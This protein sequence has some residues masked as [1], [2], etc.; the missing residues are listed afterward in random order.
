MVDFPGVAKKFFATGGQKWQN[1]ILTT[2]Y[3]KNFLLKF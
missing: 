1:F 2:R 3:E